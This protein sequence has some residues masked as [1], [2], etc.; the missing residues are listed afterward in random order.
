MRGKKTNKNKN[1]KKK[2]GGG[3]SNPVN[4]PKEVCFVQ[5]A[6]EQHSTQREREREREKRTCALKALTF[7]KAMERVGEK[8]MHS[9]RAAAELTYL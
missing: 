7:S 4:Q 1:K 3:K 6:D 9:E 5:A 2:G 8:S